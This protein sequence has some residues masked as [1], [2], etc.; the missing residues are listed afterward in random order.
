MAEPSLTYRIKSKDESK[1]GVESAKSK[2]QD[3]SKSAEQVGRTLSLLVGAGALGGVTM[4]F[5]KLVQGA[6]QAEAAFYKLHPELANTAGSAKQFGT[7]MTNVQAAIGGA[8]SG[9]LSP[10]RASIVE[11]ANKFF[12]AHDALNK[13]RG[14]LEELRN[15]DTGAS[16]TIQDQLK[17]NAESID[18]TK[19]K[20]D[21]LKKENTL[22]TQGGQI[23]T[24][25]SAEDQKRLD[26]L[27][28]QLRSLQNAQAV[29]EQ[30][31]KTIANIPKEESALQAY[32]ENVFQEQMDA[33]NEKLKYGLINPDEFNKQFESVILSLINKAQDLG[34]SL[35]NSLIAPWVQAYKDMIAAGNAMQKPAFVSKRNMDI[36]DQWDQLLLAVKRTAT[37]LGADQPWSGEQTGAP[38]YID[39]SRLLGEYSSES[40]RAS[41]AYGQTPNFDWMTLLGNVAMQLVNSL[42]SLTPIINWT[43]TII[44]GIVSVLDPF[45]TDLLAPIVGILYTL[46][47][48][49]GTILVPAFDILTPIVQ[50]LAQVF[51]WIYNWVLVPVGNGIIAIFN[52]VYNAMANFVNAVIGAYN[53]LNNLWAGTDLAYMTLKDLSE[54]FLKRITM[55]DLTKTGEDYYGA[56]AGAAATSGGASYTAGR[57]ITVNVYHYGAVVGSDGFREFALMI[58][59]EIYAAEA[60]NY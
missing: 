30:Q 58:R 53:T 42:S 47:T 55:A 21:Q 12:D 16:R 22:Y 57:D 29:L 35:S 34:V 33:L 37:E 50:A 56:Q 48:L 5:N 20:I 28:L 25:M 36:A 2:L 24:N 49:I 59:D 1:A 13:Y 39:I 6:T 46:G 32:I 31:A 15:I 19:E 18:Q 14:L 45:L 41:V 52:L 54:G 17:I 9:A 60:L 8:I 4:V 43:K 11:I 7:A 38:S 3:F 44:D 23:I 40:S 10:L 26:N 27:N 51:V